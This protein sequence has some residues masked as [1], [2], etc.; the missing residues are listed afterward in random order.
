MP[1]C[2]RFRLLLL[3]CCPM[4]LNTDVLAPILAYVNPS[5]L[6]PLCRVDST[7]YE[8]ASDRLYHHICYPE[9]LPV[10]YTLLFHPS[11]LQPKYDISRSH[12]L[13]C[14]STLFAVGKAL[15]SMTGLQSLHVADSGV[16]SGVLRRCPFRVITFSFSPQRDADL[17]GF[18]EHQEQIQDLVLGP[19]S[20]NLVLKPTAL[21]KS[22][23][24]HRGSVYS[25]LVVLST[26]LHSTILCIELS[27]MS[28]SY[29]FLLLSFNVCQS[30]LKT[31]T[32]CLL[33]TL[34]QS[35]R[36]CTFL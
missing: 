32:R 30:S 6:P 15:R 13:P 19:C 3:L 17:V 33:S 20:P 28:S 11:L 9:V 16:S 21:P 5:D 1:S 26:M 4:F 23:L 14:W 2:N 36:N 7:F 35:F 31:S 34:P 29:L 25:F 12:I 8:L 18:L 27:S 10:C 24:E 22:R